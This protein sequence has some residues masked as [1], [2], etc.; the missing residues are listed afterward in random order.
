M[1]YARMIYLDNSRVHFEEILK[2]NGEHNILVFV[3]Y[4]DY[5]QL[6]LLKISLTNFQSH[7]VNRETTVELVISLLTHKNYRIMLEVSSLFQTRK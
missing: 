1:V 3:R 2:S 7:H 4:L 6:S 5:Q